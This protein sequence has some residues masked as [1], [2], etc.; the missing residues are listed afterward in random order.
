M[1]WKKKCDRRALRSILDAAAKLDQATDAAT[2]NGATLRRAV[3]LADEMGEPESALQLKEVMRSMGMEP[4]SDDP[5]SLPSPTPSLSPEPEPPSPEPP[6]PAATDAN[7][8]TTPDAKSD[9]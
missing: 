5:P 6:T 8:D 7:S 3:V 2:L 9:T 1:T 4:S